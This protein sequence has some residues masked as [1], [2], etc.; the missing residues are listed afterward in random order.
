MA[1]ATYTD[2]LAS[3]ATYL[4]RADLTANIPDFVVL[5]EARIAR[6]LRIRKQITTTTLTAIAGNQALALPSDWLE[7]E[8]LTVNVSP[9]RNLSYM[10]VEQLDSKYPTNDYTGTPAVYTIEADSLLFGPTPDAAYSIGLIYYARFPVLSVATTNWLMTNHPGIYLFS[11]LAEAAPFIGNDERIAVW[12][13]KYRADFRS[14]QE[15][16]D[17]ATH[18]GSVL[19][20]KYL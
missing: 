17:R 15:Q 2:L 14:L 18:S 19:R 8:N 7:L 11:T 20:V 13:A 12:D 5:A 1:L 16:D 10:T 3:V 9:A 4:H 6:D